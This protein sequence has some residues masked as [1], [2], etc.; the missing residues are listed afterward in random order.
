MAGPAAGMHDEQTSRRRFL[1]LGGIA[2]GLAAAGPLLAV[3]PDAVAATRNRPAGEASAGLAAP[4]AGRR[5][6]GDHPG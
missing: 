1:P 2:G 6:R 4:A 5:D 3:A